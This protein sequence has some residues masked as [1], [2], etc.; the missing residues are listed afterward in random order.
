M[1]HQSYAYV[2]NQLQVTH[3][4]SVKDSAERGVKMIQYYLNH[5]TCDEKL[6]QCLLQTI[7]SLRKAHPTMT[8]GA[9]NMS[10]D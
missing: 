3:L 10:L 4:R 9:L 8:K 2:E 5:M 1:W 7:E 6:R